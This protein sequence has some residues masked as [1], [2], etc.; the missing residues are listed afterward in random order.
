MQ[1]VTATKIPGRPGYRVQF[2]HPLQA[3]KV[4]TFGLGTR[5][6]DFAD[7]IAADLQTI[8][9][10]TSFHHNA[11]DRRLYSFQP[12]AVAA[13]F[14]RDHDAVKR[15]AA[16]SRD[17]SPM[18]ADDFLKVAKAIWK[19][20]LEYG[21]PD[22]DGIITNPFP[23]SE[24]AFCDLLKQHLGEYSPKKFREIQD[25]NKKLVNELTTA[26]GKIA[27]IQRQLE[28]IEKKYAVNVKATVE[29]VAKIWADVYR[30]QV[31]AKTYKEAKRAVDLFTASLPEKTKLVDV[32]AGKIESW[33]NSLIKTDD[34]GKA[35]PIAAVTRKKTRQYLCVFVTWAVQRYTLPINPI[36]AVRVKSKAQDSIDAITDEK[37]L[38]KLTESLKPDPYWQ[39][40]VAVCCFAGP[41]Y[42][43]L[44]NMKL[45]DINL[46][47]NEFRIA[48]VKTGKFRRVPVEQSTLRPILDAYLKTVRPKLGDSSYLFPSIADA[49][50][51]KPRTLTPEGVW[52]DNGVFL[53]YFRAATAKRVPVT[54]KHYGPREFRHT[55]GTVLG[56]IGWGSREIS[57]TMGNSESVANRFYIAKSKHGTRWSFK[58]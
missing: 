53:D 14:G 20:C 11:D 18:D 28:T 34:T 3:D 55:F 24:S 25:T 35:V 30:N 9:N 48:G 38:I 45:S 46:D 16:V 51:Y 49:A 1:Y 44:I 5:D 22:E 50:L 21:A 33:L 12:L 29:D 47:A 41:R 23:S 52:S 17:D 31:A 57:E 56:M 10:D 6:K 2:R 7:A 27:D 4:I 39:T 26:R 8:L 15:I 40:I 54:I 13:F 37:V 19:D 43:E 42:S 36:T 58:Y 32:D